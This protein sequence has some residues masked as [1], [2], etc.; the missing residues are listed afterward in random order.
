MVSFI[1]FEAVESIVIKSKEEQ[2]KSLQN[3]CYFPVSLLF[4]AVDLLQVS[5][6][7]FNV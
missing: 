7:N 4:S 1:S 2:Q 5:Q 6:R 3:M